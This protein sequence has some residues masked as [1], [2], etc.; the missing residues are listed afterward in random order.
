MTKLP[1]GTRT[2]RA[3]KVAAPTTT[4]RVVAALPAAFVAVSLTV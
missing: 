4:V 2:H 3:V 1:P